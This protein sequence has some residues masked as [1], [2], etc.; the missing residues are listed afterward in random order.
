MREEENEIFFF[1][2]KEAIAVMGFR[3]YL[4]SLSENDGDIMFKSLILEAELASR[5]SMREKKFIILW[6][7]G[8]YYSFA[9]VTESWNSNQVFLVPKAFPFFC[10]LFRVL[11]PIP[12]AHLFKDKNQTPVTVFPLYRHGV[13]PVLY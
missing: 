11:L 6:I 4:E 8:G 12:F 13:I 1:L 7:Q 3:G 2:Q 9:S 5:K 10:H